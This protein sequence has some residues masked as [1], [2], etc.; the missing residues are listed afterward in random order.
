MAAEAAVAAIHRA[1]V[2]SDTEAVARML[3]EDPRLLTTMWGGYLLLA[4]AAM[5]G[6]VGTV[7]LLLERGTDVNTTDRD[8]TTALGYAAFNGREE[9]VSLLLGS[10]ADVYRRGASGATALLYA[11]QRGHV[12]VVRLLL[13]SMGG[14][15]LDE[16][17][18]DGRTALYMACSNGRADVL[19]ALLLAG[20]DH[21]IAE[22]DGTTPQQI[23]QHRG[24]PECAALIQVSNPNRSTTVQ[25]MGIQCIACTDRSSSVFLGNSLRERATSGNTSPIPL[26]VHPICM[27]AVVGGRAGACLCPPQGQDAT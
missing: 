26:C 9:V 17:D 10:G 4:R 20:A 22:N 19:R 15:G 5:R 12:A 1:T 21:T 2:M 18:T 6:H 23:A 13:R 16:R 8:G 3:D 27:L 14:C 7:K 24:H 25:F 11:S